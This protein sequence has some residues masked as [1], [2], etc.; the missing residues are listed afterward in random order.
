AFSLLFLAV[1]MTIVIAER[2]WWLPVLF[3]I[4]ANCHG[5]VVL[6]LVVVSVALV[7]SLDTLQG[8][9]RPVAVMVAG[10]AAATPPPLGISFW[11]EM[12]GAVAGISQYPIDEWRAPS[13][14]EMPLAPFWLAAGAV[15]IGVALQWRALLKPDHR[16]T[17]TLCACALA[18]LPLAV[19]AVR[20]VGPF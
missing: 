4:W 17:R 15:C 16:R 10:V 9:R 2:V 18:V 1:A 5:G 8:W 12:V 13:L 20:N 19:T 3:F 7:T 14:G 11:S 6:G